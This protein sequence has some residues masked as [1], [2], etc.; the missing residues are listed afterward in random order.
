MKVTTK[1]LSEFE[2]VLDWL[3][4]TVGAKVSPFALASFTYKMGLLSGAEFCVLTDKCGAVCVKKEVP[5]NW[6]DDDK[7]EEIQTLKEMVE[8]LGFYIIGGIVDAGA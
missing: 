1:S 7:I 3:K 8:K 5:I 4:E 2:E 6:V